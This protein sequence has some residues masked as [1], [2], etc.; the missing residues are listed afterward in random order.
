VIKKSLPKE[1]GARWGIILEYR[2]DGKGAGRRR[3]ISEIA[4][5]MKFIDEVCDARF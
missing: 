1:A 5:S 3:E 4:D 2:S